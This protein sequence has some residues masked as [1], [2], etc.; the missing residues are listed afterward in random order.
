VRTRT[1]E[2]IIK[3]MYDKIWEKHWP[4]SCPWLFLCTGGPPSLYRHPCLAWFPWSVPADRTREP[5]CFDPTEET[6]LAE[7]G[8]VK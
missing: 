1:E 4:P 6:M 8:E 5:S 2:E 3:A 7:K